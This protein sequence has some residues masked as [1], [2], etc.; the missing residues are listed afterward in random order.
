MLVIWFRVLMSQKLRSRE[1]TKVPAP[2]SHGSCTAGRPDITCGEGRQEL[3]VALGKGAVVGPTA[4]QDQ[5]DPDD[6]D[7]V[8]AG[9]PSG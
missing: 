6:G 9:R 3:D 1:S 8:P 2:R 5:G 4:V 7:A